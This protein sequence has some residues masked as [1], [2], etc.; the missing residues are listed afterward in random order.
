[1]KV[2]KE[3]EDR[4]SNN[5]KDKIQFNNEYKLYKKPFLEMMEEFAFM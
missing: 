5:S 1:M 2:K 3:D 4:L